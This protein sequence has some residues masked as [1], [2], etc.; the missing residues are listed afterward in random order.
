MAQ[1][2]TIVDSHTERPQWV[3]FDDGSSECFR[4]TRLQQSTIVATHLADS[5][6]NAVCA[7][8]GMY[9]DERDGNALLSRDVRRV[10]SRD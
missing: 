4:P 6:C 1:A 10:K 7:C 9:R 3:D 2:T 8:R 5:G